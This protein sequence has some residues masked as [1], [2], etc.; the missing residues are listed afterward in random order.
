MIDYVILHYITLEFLELPMYKTA[1]PAVPCFLCLLLLK[2]VAPCNLGLYSVELLEKQNT[3]RSHKGESQQT[4]HHHG[5]D[6]T[7]EA[8]T[9]WTHTR[10]A[11]CEIIVS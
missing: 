2:L 5:C 3:Q 4:P 11:G 6:Q 10:Y 8:T 9:V 1:I 7:Q